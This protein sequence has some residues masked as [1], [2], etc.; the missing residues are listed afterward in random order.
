MVSFDVLSVC[1]PYLFSAKAWIPVFTPFSLKRQKHLIIYPSAPVH[2][3]RSVIHTVN[4]HCGHNSVLSVAVV[5][6]VI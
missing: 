5:L 3:S 6:A 1:L 4:L 2:T